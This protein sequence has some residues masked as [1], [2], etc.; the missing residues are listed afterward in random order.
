MT[1]EFLCKTHEIPF[2]MDLLLKH[3]FFFVCVSEHI[4]TYSTLQHSWVELILLFCYIDTELLLTCIG[5]LLPMVKLGMGGRA[6]YVLVRAVS[7]R[8]SIDPDVNDTEGGRENA[9]TELSKSYIP[10]VQQVVFISQI[11]RARNDAFS[12]S[13]MSLDSRA[14]RV[15]QFYCLPVM[16]ELLTMQKKSKIL[17]IKSKSPVILRFYLFLLLTE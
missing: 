5:R 12:D 8:P 4:Y 17:I 9:V 14:V 7:G 16:V 2:E 15:V 10:T 3:R 6:L 11:S 13:W 1:R